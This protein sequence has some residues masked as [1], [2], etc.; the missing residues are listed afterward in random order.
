MADNRRKKECER[1]GDIQFKKGRD[2]KR[3]EHR[4]SKT[5]KDRRH[6]IE[7]LRRDETQ[8]ETETEK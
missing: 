2:Q 4:E 3:M 6:R 5:G 8:R 1:E 7:L